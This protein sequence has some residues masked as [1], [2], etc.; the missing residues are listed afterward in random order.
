MPGK[1]DAVKHKSHGKNIKPTHEKNE[2]NVLFLAMK[3]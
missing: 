3:G 1:T 2:W